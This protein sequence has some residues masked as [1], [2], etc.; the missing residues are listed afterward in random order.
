MS[1]SQKT[2]AQDHASF[3]SFD[4]Q[5]V[6]GIGEVLPPPLD[7]MLMKHTRDDDV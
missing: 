5:T 2:G 4:D 3:S 6:C 7:Q 1:I